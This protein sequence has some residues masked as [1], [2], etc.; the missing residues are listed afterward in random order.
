MAS[1]EDVTAEISTMVRTALEY[2]CRKPKKDIPPVSS[3]EG[4]KT[5]LSFKSFLERD[6][7]SCPMFSDSEKL[8]EPV[9]PRDRC[10]VYACPGPSGKETK[11]MIGNV[12]NM[13]HLVELS[14]RL[15]A[16]YD[17]KPRE[18]TKKT[19]GLRLIVKLKESFYRGVFLRSR[20]VSGFKSEV[21]LQD[22]KFNIEVTTSNL[23]AMP[24][25]EAR[26][27]DNSNAFQEILLDKPLP[28][29]LQCTFQSFTMAT[30][31]WSLLL[32]EDETGIHFIIQFC[33]Y[34][35]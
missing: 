15:K 18:H 16:V 4:I 25:E 21:Y 6:T 34:W 20:I 35:K 14:R 26:V 1:N 28:P 2:S 11:I 3:P 8:F 23:R 12:N 33:L 17:E 22:L 13:T 24:L 9:Q 19:K 7:S 10:F 30:N 27:N 32:P 31:G 5:N 29:Y